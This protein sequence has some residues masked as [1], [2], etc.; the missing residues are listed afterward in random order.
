MSHPHPGSLPCLGEFLR[1][2]SGTGRNE[3]A[4]S[5]TQS[6][7]ASNLARNGIAGL[8]GTP[9]VIEGRYE[10]WV[11]LDRREDCANRSTGNFM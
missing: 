4:H 2:G 6:R 3:M 1:L 11:W 7:G 8:L 10:Y 5:K 9:S